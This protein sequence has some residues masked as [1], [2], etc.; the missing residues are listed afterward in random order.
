MLV[1]VSASS[2]GLLD[3]RAPSYIL[4][5]IGA[6]PYEIALTTAATK[7]TFRLTGARVNTTMTTAMSYGIPCPVSALSYG[8]VRASV[9]VYKL[10]DPRDPLYN[11]AESSTTTHELSHTRTV[12][13]STGSSRA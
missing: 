13:K 4:A 8:L 6:T 9:S 7:R 11:L 12:M 2:C 5:V 1:R 10:Q 3:T